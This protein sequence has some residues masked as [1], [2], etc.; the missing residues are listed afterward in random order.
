MPFGYQLPEQSNN[1]EVIGGSAWGAHTLANGDGSRQP[2]QTELKFAKA[3]GE[4]FA[5]VVNQYV[6]GA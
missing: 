6:K 5:K 4:H 3:Q 2:S 1:D